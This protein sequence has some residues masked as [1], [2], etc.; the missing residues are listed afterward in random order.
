MKVMT[1]LLLSEYATAS[2]LVDPHSQGRDLPLI[3]RF[4]AS[5]A[6]SLS[7]IPSGTSSP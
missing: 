3:Q 7:P 1:P 4:I 5:C 6:A 2:I